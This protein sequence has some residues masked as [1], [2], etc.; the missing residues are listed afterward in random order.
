MAHWVSPATLVRLRVEGREVDA[1]ANSGSQ[2]I[3][4]TVTSGYVCQHEFPVLLLCDLVD[5]PLNLVA[6]GGM[7]TH[8]LGFVILRVQVNKIAGYNKDVV[9]LVVPEFSQHVPIVIGTCMLGRIV[10]VIKESEMDKLSTPWVMVRASRLLSQW[11]TVVENLGMAGEGPIEEGAAAAEPLMGQN[12]DDPVFMRENVRLGSFQT[13]I[14]ECRVKPL[15]G[16]SAHV[17]VMPLRASK[18]QPGGA[19]PLPPGLHIV[20]TYTRLKMSR[21]SVVVRNMSESSIFLKKGVEV[22]RVVSTSP[23]PPTEL[24]P[25]WKAILG[26][27]DKQEPLSVAETDQTPREV[28]SGWS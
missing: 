20:H 1:L 17:M 4:N 18:T 3:L 2:V 28:E 23:I 12:L 24:S 19:W 25:E 27:E 6:L 16:E 22:V 13:Q 8:P 11:G 21:V 10:N 9:F 7:R 15:I 14:L 26:M 5:H